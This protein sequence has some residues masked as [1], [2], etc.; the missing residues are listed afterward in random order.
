MGWWQFSFHLSIL[1]MLALPTGGVGCILIKWLAVC[2]F[3]HRGSG[4]EGDGGAEREG[5]RWRSRK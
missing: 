5:E 3:L 1:S 2:S 4:E